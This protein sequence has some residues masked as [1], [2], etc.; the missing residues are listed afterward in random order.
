[1]FLQCQGTPN[2]EARSSSGTLFSLLAR[3]TLS[4]KKRKSLSTTPHRGLKTSPSYASGKGGKTHQ[5]TANLLLIRALTAGPT[6]PTAPLLPSGPGGPY[7]Q[8]E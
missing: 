4:A 6:A 1:M 8:K 2:L 5:S 7:T 3:T